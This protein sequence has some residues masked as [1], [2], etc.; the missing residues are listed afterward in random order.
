[1][2]EQEKTCIGCQQRLSGNMRVGPEVP[3][4]IALGMMKSFWENTRGTTTIQIRKHILWGKKSQMPG[5][6]MICTATCGSGARI[7]MDTRAHG[8]ILLGHHRVTTV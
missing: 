6:C 2:K 5:V 8:L 7:G 4:P 1:M 3:E